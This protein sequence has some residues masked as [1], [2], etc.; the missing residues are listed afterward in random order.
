[1][2]GLTRRQFHIGLIAGLG[3]AVL[4][5]QVVAQTGEWLD[6]PRLPIRVQEIYPALVNGRIFVAGGL[7]PDVEGRIIGI[8]DRLFSWRPDEMAGSEHPALPMPAHHGNCIEHD[9]CLYCIGGFVRGDQDIW[10]N[11]AAVQVYDP[12]TESWSSGPNLPEPQA[13]TVLGAIE[14]RL[15]LVGGRRTRDP[16]SDRYEDQYDVGEHLVLDGERWMTAAPMPT[17][18]NSAGGATIEG[19]LHVVGGRTMAGGN[20]SVHEAYDAMADRW[21]TLAPLPEPEQ[22]P[23]GAGGLAVA[24]IGEAL[25]AFGGEWLTDGGGVYRQVWRWDGDADQWQEETMMPLPRHGLGAVTMNDTIYTI[26]GATGRG[27]D[28]TSDVV[29]AY[30]PI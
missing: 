1:M 11:S 28:G 13:E 8:S 25:Y 4:P 5:R 30:R 19:R 10:R 18:R 20:L 14:G 22:G 9:G 16:Q 21:M 23:P 27:I 3:L 12:Q 7:S 24:A 29:A 6:A 26:G 2:A 15:H 17:A